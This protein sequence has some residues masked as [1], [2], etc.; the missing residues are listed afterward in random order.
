MLS[1]DINKIVQE[2]DTLVFVTPSPY[3]KALLK[4]LK[5]KLNTKANL[6]GYQGY[7]S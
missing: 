6:N 1:S 2:Y 7:C 3:L 4:K 5:T